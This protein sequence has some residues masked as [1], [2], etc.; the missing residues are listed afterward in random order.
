[1]VSI[2]PKG[3]QPKP[4]STEQT[5][6]AKPGA[7]AAASTVS[8][9]VAGAGAGATGALKDKF[10]SAKPGA[11]QGT[12]VGAHGIMAGGCCIPPPPFKPPQIGGNLGGIGSA[13]EGA[14]L[15]M[16]RDAAKDKYEATSKDAL[17]DGKIDDREQRKI[18]AAGRDWKIAEKKV[19]L[20]E[21]RE[22]HKKAT[23]DALKDGYISDKE[24]KAI[25][26]AQGKI[27]KLQ[28]QLDK[29]VAKDKIQDA[30]DRIL[31]AFDG[32]KPGLKP[33][34]PQDKF[35]PIGPG[36]LFP[37]K[38]WK[39]L[40]DFKLPDLKLPDFKLPDFKLPDLK[41]PDLGDLKFPKLPTFPEPPV[42][43]CRPPMLEGFKP[44][45]LY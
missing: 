42:W 1:M 30:A 14:L 20:H 19:D 17:K 21:A 38:D 31:D 15:R 32:A 16:G 7:E 37:P 28:T 10:E 26:A 22:A 24:Q 29:M 27:D 18:N 3:S 9:S 44:Q 6:A 40:P 11:F 39:P 2:Q 12:K 34:I 33:G 41:L 13:L 8:K 35:P 25:N 4:V 5:T 23:A 45:I 36:G 43:T